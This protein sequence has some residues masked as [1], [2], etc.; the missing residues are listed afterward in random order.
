MNRKLTFKGDARKKLAEGVEVMYN[1]VGTTLGPLGR[2]VAIGREWGPP[3]VVHDG[4]TVAR[5]VTSDDEF[6]KMGIDL[7]REAAGKTNDEAG[8]GTTTATVMSHNLVKYGMQEVEAG[9]NPMKLRREINKALDQAKKALEGVVVE[10]KSDEEVKRV[11][12]ISADNQ[13]IGD[14]VAKAVETVGKDGV[15]TVEQHAQPNTILDVSE[16]LQV[17]HGYIVPHFITNGKTMEAVIDDAL[18]AVVDGKITTQKEIVPL[19]ESMVTRGKNIVVF[20]DIGG[21]ALEFCVKNKMN[22]NVSILCVDPPGYKDRRENLMQ[23]IAILTGAKVIKD[24]IGLSPQD[25][26]KQFDIDVMIGHAEKVIASRKKT[27]IIDGSGDPAQVEDRVETLRQQKTVETNEFEREKIE[28]RLSKLSTGV[29]VIRV[30]AKTNVEQRET[31]ERVKDAVFSAQ[32]AVQEGVVPGGGVTF[33]KMADAISGLTR[34]EVV[35][36]KAL[37]AHIRKI[38]ENAGEDE[39]QIEKISE[40][41][42]NTLGPVGYDMETGMIDDMFKLGIIDPARVVRLALENA[43]SVATSILTTDALIAVSREQDEPQN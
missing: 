3:I 1:A 19:L 8:D 10:V 4:V 27:I 15:I 17:D 37:R 43:T 25:F 40:V 18:I 41:L 24:E 34:G 12:K 2:N 38:L 13:E 35:F 9:Y 6:V 42:E 21:Q 11:A 7:V 16:G 39:D 14:I 5:D 22:G 36:I 30:G 31:E 33:L 23:D 32:A 20:G 29:A 28:E 26:V